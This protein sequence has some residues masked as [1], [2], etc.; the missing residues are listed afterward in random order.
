M[1]TVASYNSA[2]SMTVAILQASALQ[3]TYPTTP[4][5]SVAQYASATQI[6]NAI[7]QA[8]AEICTAIINTPQHPYQSQFVTTS[9]S[10]STGVSGG[11]ALPIRNGMVLKI[12][13]INSGASLPFSP[14]IVNVSGAINFAANVYA[15]QGLATG[16]RVQLTT[17]GALPDP[18]TAGLN[19]WV[20]V[21]NGDVET[22][23]L[24]YTPYDAQIGNFVEFT[25]TGTGNSTIVP[26]YE[27]ATPALSKD[28]VTAATLYPQIYATTYPNSSMFWFIEGDY[29]FCT[30]ALSKVVYTDYT[31]TSTTQ[32]PEPYLN[33]IVAGAVS[34]LA[35]D[36]SDSELAAYY[37]GIYQQMMQSIV[38][39]AKVLPEIQS[40]KLA[41]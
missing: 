22:T 25:D 34:R 32:A 9:P 8:D 20:Y 7:L 1:A 30:S 33:A 38:A 37:G 26:Q 4:D 17:T 23:Y 16:M 12:L 29:L 14:A 40:Y 24:C 10:L 19:Y 21:P 11:V 41:A 35:L 15:T 27:E 13:G 18:L 31:L 39:M 36:G 28:Q 3:S 2:K 5:G 6:N